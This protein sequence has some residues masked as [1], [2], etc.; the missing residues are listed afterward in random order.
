M[1]EFQSPP[2]SGIMGFSPN[3][4]FVWVQVPPEKECNLRWTKSPRKLGQIGHGTQSGMLCEQGRRV[5]G[6]WLESQ[7]KPVGCL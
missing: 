3:L 6:G 7:N 5:A 2:K 1:H 4:S